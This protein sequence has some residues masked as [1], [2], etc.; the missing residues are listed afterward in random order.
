MCET[1]RSWSLFALYMFVCVLAEEKIRIEK[2][3]LASR[4]LLSNDKRWSRG[5]YFLS[6]PFTNTGFFLLTIKFNFVG[7]ILKLL[8]MVRYSSRMSWI[9]ELICRT[10]IALTYKEQRNS[11]INPFMPAQFQW[12]LLYVSLKL[13]L[14]IKKKFYIHLYIEVANCRS[15]AENALWF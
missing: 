9:L 2:Q 8:Y 11:L 4:G 15:Y 13:S 1:S 12:L 5:T 14:L 6:H 7:H 10:S 3:T